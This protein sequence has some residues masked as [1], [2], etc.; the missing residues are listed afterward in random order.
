MAVGRRF[1]S[2]LP[3]L[4]LSAAAVTFAISDE[5]VYTVYL[6][7]G[8]IFKAGT[9]SKIS[10]TFGNAERGVVAVPDLRTWGLMGPD[11]DYYERGHRDI[12]SGRGP[13]VKGPLCWLNLTSDGSGDHPSWFC[14]Y[15]EVTATGPHRG[16][17]QGIFYV[18]QWLSNDAPPFQLTALLDGCSQVP[19]DV[20]DHTRSGPLVVSRNNH[21]TDKEKAASQ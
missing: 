6:R 8:Q 4:L 16:C 20:D 12:F 2:L 7:T 13:C 1:P 19:P 10:A 15:L 18:N 21:A 11:Y 9:N 17:S 14:D 3:F 5:C